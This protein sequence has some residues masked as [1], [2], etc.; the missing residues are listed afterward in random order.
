[1]PGEYALPN[2]RL[3][4]IQEKTEAIGCVALKSAGNNQCKMKRLYVRLQSHGQHFGRLLITKLIDT[5]RDIGYSEMRFETLSH[6]VSAISLYR[7]LGFVVSESTYQQEDLH[8]VFRNGTA[9]INPILL[10]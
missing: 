5:A 10:A 6:W 7:Q 1:L 3:F 2:G 8:L 4:L 9:L